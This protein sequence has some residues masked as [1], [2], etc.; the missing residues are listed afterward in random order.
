MHITVH[1]THK[2]CKGNVVEL[3]VPANQVP[4]IFRKITP[5]ALLAAMGKIGVSG[6]KC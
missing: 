3:A 2:Q 1:N 6:D 4:I 5:A